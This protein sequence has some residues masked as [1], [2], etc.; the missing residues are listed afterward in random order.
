MTEQVRAAPALLDDLTRALEGRY[1][2]GEG[3][4]FGRGGVTVRA[5]RVS[6][7]RNVALKVAWEDR[8]ARA[9]VLRE[10]AITA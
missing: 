8:A 2:V 5:R 7:G 1:V 3:I 6:S 9:Q 4:G 10:T